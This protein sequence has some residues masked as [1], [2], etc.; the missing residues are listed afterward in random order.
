MALCVFLVSP[1]VN[2]TRILFNETFLNFEITVDS[3][4]IIRNNTQRSPVLFVQLP[5]IPVSCKSVALYHNQ[6]IHIETVKIQNIS[7]DTRICHVAFLQHHIFLTHHQ[8][9]LNPGNR[10]SVLH[11]YNIVTFRMLYKWKYIACKLWDLLFSLREILG[12]SIYIVA[13]VNGSLFCW[14][15]FLGRNVLQQI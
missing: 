8:D 5:T 13:C 1:T 9:P 14:V 11:F 4:V 2:L 10:C 12:R 7:I 15:L 6:D 3:H